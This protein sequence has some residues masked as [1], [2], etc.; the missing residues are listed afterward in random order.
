MWAGADIEDREAVCLPVVGRTGVRATRA[1]RQDP[2]T[3]GQSSRRPFV[4]AFQVRP[5]QTGP[6]A[7]S[8]VAATFGARHGAE[9]D[10]AAR[11]GIGAGD[12]RAWPWSGARCVTPRRMIRLRRGCLAAPRRLPFQ[13]RSHAASRQALSCTLGCTL[14]SDQNAGHRATANRRAA[15]RRRQGPKAART[16]RGRSGA[17]RLARCRAQLDDRPRDGRR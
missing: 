14:S 10:A 8:R 3:G 16:A 17:K 9:R 7:M 6:G 2:A 15:R 11:T 1:D 12:V 5:R 13:C 4:R